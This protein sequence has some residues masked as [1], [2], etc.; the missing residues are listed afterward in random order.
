MQPGQFRLGFSQALAVARHL[1]FGAAYLRRDLVGFDP[2]QDLAGGDVV[3]L[4]HSHLKQLTRQLGGDLD[5]RRLDPAIGAG[6]TVGQAIFLLFPPER[7]AA[8]RQTGQ[9]NQTK[10]H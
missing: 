6:E 8:A 10:D 9:H 4:A 5:L 2:G 1:G 3:A 7:V